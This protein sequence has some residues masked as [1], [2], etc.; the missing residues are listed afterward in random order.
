MIGGKTI[1]KINVILFVIT[2][3]LRSYTDAVYEAKGIHGGLIVDFKYVTLLLGIAFC[4]LQL[5]NRKKKFG[6]YQKVFIKETY[7]VVFAIISIIVLSLLESLI[8]TGIDASSEMILEVFKLILPILYAYLVLNTFEFEDIYSSMK[9]IL[10]FSLAGYVLEIG[11]NTFTLSNIQRINFR[12]SYSPFESHYAAGSAIAMC[13]FFMYYRKNKALEI[14]SFLFAL[15][16]FK[17]AAVLFAIL[18]FILPMIFDMSKLVKKRTVNVFKIGFIV[19]TYLYYQL[20]LPSNE[21]LFE[22]VFK[23]D[24]QMFTMG[25]SAYIAQLVYAGFESTGFGSTTLFIGK[26]IEM[27]LIK[28]MLEVGIIGLLI[29]VWCYF[30]CAGRIR[31]SLL[32]MTFVFFNLLTS[33][34]LTNAFNWILTFVI[35][36]TMNYK[37]TEDISKYVRR[38][39]RKKRF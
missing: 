21:N 35:L 39:Q 19:S 31:Y 9:F 20:Q 1:R 22:R 2:F 7:F 5:W 15:A 4:L 18:I 36:G 6:Q 29:F 11:T 28:I 23:V 33:H 24:A 30:E 26:S 14:I 12:T 13:T 17:R 34:S 16:T 37:E 3:A 27:D 8:H 10:F 25:R 38:K 32:Y